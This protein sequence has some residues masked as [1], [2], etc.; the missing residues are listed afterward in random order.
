MSNL[1]ISFRIDALA[2]SLPIVAEILNTD[3]ERTAQVVVWNNQSTKVAISPGKYMVRAQ[4]PSGA[5]LR[6]IVE[7]PADDSTF[8]VLL[9][10]PIPPTAETAL[11]HF[12]GNIGKRSDVPLPAQIFGTTWLMLWSWRD[13]AWHHE[14]WHG[15]TPQGTTLG[16]IAE[17]KLSTDRVWL[18]QIGGDTVP[19]RF[20][21]IP[22]SPKIEILVRG[23]AKN[24]TSNGGVSVRTITHN[25]EA[26]VLMHYEVSGATES[27]YLI[28]KAI[29]SRLGR[30]KTDKGTDPNATALGFYCMLANRQLGKGS[31]S[32]SHFSK[33]S[34]WL[35]DA[36]LIAAMYSLTKPRGKDTVRQAKDQLLQASGAAIPVYTRGLRTLFDQ[37]GAYK[38]DEDTP[39][40]ENVDIALRR[41]SR[42][43]AA[44][45]WNSV[46]TSFFG[47]NPADPSPDLMFG[48]CKYGEAVYLD[49]Y[50]P[51][52]AA[53]SAYEAHL[54]TSMSADP[55]ELGLIREARDKNKVDKDVRDRAMAQLYALYHKELIGYLRVRCPVK[56]EVD[57]IAQ[58]A[59]RHVFERIDRF[60]DRRGPFI[61]FLKHWAQI[62]TLRWLRDQRAHLAETYLMSDLSEDRSGWSTDE[63]TRQPVR[64]W[65]ENPEEK[66]SV[67]QQ[68]MKLL[69]LTFATP[70][71]PHQL[72]AFA[73]CKV[74]SWTPS[75]FV[76]RMTDL[77]LRQ[78][79]A[80]FQNI[81]VNEMPMEA[82]TVRRALRHLKGILQK[83]FDE[84]I[85]D[86][87]TR[88]TYSN[89]RSSIIGETRLR[90]YFRKEPEQNVSHWIYAVRRRTLAAWDEKG[91]NL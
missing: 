81:L 55:I 70:S 56:R 88:S 85:Q 13:D 90:D 31:P 54:H 9:E 4:L 11:H 39:Y 33:H 18:L 52:I 66:F 59:W 50:P 35:P 29:A 17:L 34:S 30:D 20:I 72:L 40:D 71:P 41:V 36:S 65:L 38:Q 83:T 69:D 87:A 75:V 7:V 77:D 42:Y 82:D 16:V 63:L 68:Y 12:L 79:E 76:E 49:F 43:A 48:S 6:Q 45:D 84:V 74:L 73:F 80:Q 24:T 15:T 10:A 78:I 46:R 53:H 8:E 61:A 22:P 26:E 58:E 91:P 32:P 89:L 2:Y 1:E 5:V 60:D 57:D 23:T 86:P 27:A 51:G 3:L 47:T 37:L 14:N 62:A 25:T 21:A 64:S 44:A 67:Y 19:H 28:G